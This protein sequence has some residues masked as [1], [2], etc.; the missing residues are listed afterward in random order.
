MAPATVLPARVDLPPGII[1]AAV[2][3]LGTSWYERG[4]GYW[5]RRV[6]VVIA[7][8]FGLACETAILYGLFSAAYRNRI[9]FWILVAVEITCT[10]GLWIYLAIRLRR[11]R[12]RTEIGSTSLNPKEARRAGSGGATVGILAR[13]GS[14]VAGLFL[15]VGTLLT[16]GLILFIFVR[17]FLPQ[18]DT[19]R[20]AR[21]G[22]IAELRKHP[23]T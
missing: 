18:L 23:T 1:I 20:E 11:R 2:P 13:S 5:V 15:V 9:A 4:V 10:V 17:A 21:A 3:G 14:V 8:A 16:Y 22:L 19:E 7:M 12:N 6:F